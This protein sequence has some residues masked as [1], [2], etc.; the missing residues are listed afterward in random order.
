MLK[1]KFTKIYSA[2]KIPL[3]LAASFAGGLVFSIPFLS[4]SFSPFAVSFSAALGGWYSLAAAL[5]SAAGF[6]SFHTGASSFRYFAALVVSASALRISID[7]FRLK[8]DKLLKILCP[9]L[10]TLAVNCIYL[11]AQKFSP[12]LAAGIAVETALTAAAVPVFSEGVR[13]LLHK[14]LT[15]KKGKEK[16]AVCLLLLLSMITAHLNYFDPV[17]TAVMIFCNYLMILCFSYSRDFYGGTVAGIC[18]AFTYALEGGGDF[19]CVAM[20]M[21]G[22]ACDFFELGRYSGAAVSFLCAAA[23]CVMSENVSLVNVLPAAASAAVFCLL[24]NR[25]LYYE[26]APASEIEISSFA[27]SDNAKKLAGAVE[28]IGECMSAVRQSLVPFE[29]PRLEAEIKKARE[30][31]CGTCELKESCVNEIRN[32]DDS[33]YE[34]TA[35]SVISGSPCAD[36]F[37]ENFE[38]TCYRSAQMTDEI[39]MA[40]Y[41]YR[42]KVMAQNKINRIQSLAGDQFRTFGGVIGSACTT[43]ER[44]GTAEKTHCYELLQTAKEYGLN[45]KKAE[46]CKDKAGRDYFELTFIKPENNFSVNELLR[47]ICADTGFELDFPTLIQKDREYT[48]IFK[49]KERFEFKIAA[50]SVPSTGKGVCG[51]YYRCFKDSAGRQIV[52]LSDGMGTGGRAAVDSAFT[53]ETVSNLL[54]AGMDI[55]TAVAALNSAMIMKST[56]ESLATVDLL[57]IDPVSGTAE[58]FKCGAAPTFISSGK[59]QSVL[60]PESTPVGILDNVNMAFSELQADEGDFFLLVSDGVSCERYRWIC[61]ELS[62]RQTDSPSELARHILTCARDRLLGKRLDDMTVIAVIVK[63]KQG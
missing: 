45:V 29:K 38:T 8:R 57:R 23:G 15:I 35:A 51:D 22:C 33:F 62:A 54:K 49:Q 58:I 4:G 52:L 63:G 50:A 42:T 11:L 10:S 61:S 25:L 9:A 48:L 5:G 13:L 7:V 2:L 16:N 12:G 27:F 20:P 59:N 34:K 1:A 19:L 40:Y 26:E 46:R 43:L 28:S 18:C 53:C 44:T 3:R 55:K 60:D 21:C 30:R 32:A 36:S 39:N 14:P 37:P 41:T 31:T 47:K 24:P 56:D 6:F 17:G